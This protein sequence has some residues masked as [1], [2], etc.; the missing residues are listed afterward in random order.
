MEGQTNT[1]KVGR[2]GGS[3][4]GGLKSSINSRAKKKTI[5]QAAKAAATASRNR[6]KQQEKQQQAESGTNS[7]NNNPEKVRAKSWSRRWV[8]LPVEFRLCS[9]LSFLDTSK[10]CANWSLTFWRSRGRGQIKNCF[11]KSRG[12]S[13]DSPTTPNVHIR[14]P[15][16]FKQSPKFKD[17]CGGR[18]KFWAV[19]RRGVLAEPKS[20]THQQKS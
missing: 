3:T 5:A 12:A 8:R 14:V 2:E 10:I 16:R 4:V 18:A 9:R 13:H 11:C 6:H 19:R 17:N 1:A 7:I 20:W 15:S